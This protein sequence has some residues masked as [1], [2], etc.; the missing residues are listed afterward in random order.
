M[1]ASQAAAAAAGGA[2]A[3]P[4]APPATDW[5]WT[6]GRAAIMYLGVQFVMGP[7][8]PFASKKGPQTQPSAQ[9][10][11]ASGDPTVV[12]ASSAV[13]ARS[14][15]VL[16]GA[17]VVPLAAYGRPTV[18]AWSQDAPLDFYVY[19]SSAPAPTHEDLLT[20]SSEL[21][22]GGGTERAPPVPFDA[23]PQLLQDPFRPDA[24]S[25]AHVVYAPANGV[26][27]GSGSGSLRPIAAAKWS[28]IGLGDFAMTR[29]VDFTLKLDDQVRSNNGSIWADLVVT[30]R[31]VALNKLDRA[32]ARKAVLRTRKLLTRLLPLKRKRE[33][34]NLFGGSS[35]KSGSEAEAGEPDA[36]EDA[37]D[38][39]APPPLVGHWHTNLSVALVQ[40]DNNPQIQLQQLPPPLRQY[41]HV[42]RDGAGEKLQDPTGQFD[43]RF[44]TVFPNDFWLLKEHMTP[45]NETVSEVRL[46]IHLYHQT[47]FK[48]QILA[49]VSDAFDKQAS[50]AGGGGG[51]GAS[52]T[53]SEIDMLKTMLLETNPWF[54]AL[55]VTVSLLHSLF[56]FLAFSSDVR[57]WKNKDNLAGVS[58]GSILTNV[59]VQIIITLYLLDNNEETSWMILAGQAV[60]VLIEVW[61]LTKA[62]TV[63]L[64]AAPPGSLVPFRLKISDKHV[65]SEEEK[66]TQEYDKLA[67][68]YVGLVAVPVLVAYTVYSALYQTHRGWWSFIISTATSF[69][70]AFGF[71]SLVPQLIVNYKLKSTAGMNTKTFV[72]KIL[73]TFVDDLFA[74]C[75]KMPTLHRLAC[76]RDDIVFFIFL[77]QRWIYGIDPTRR[78]EFGQVVDPKDDQDEGGEKDKVKAGKP[79][80]P[81]TPAVGALKASGREEQVRDGLRPRGSATA[82]EAKAEQ[83]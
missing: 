28:D 66:R 53:G 30:P 55:T 47:F 51:M 68:K 83:E 75:I 60:G 69:V 56:E 58:L 16:P 70:Y 23:F 79:T 46:H 27:S 43:L 22:A 1:P 14:S 2:P 54:L 32:S 61:K 5:K 77:Y 21:V 48:F 76:F 12:D 42:P 8:G 57:H 7:N 33:E 39:K 78:N 64:V 49:S 26:A 59:V 24:G 44:P 18:P 34:K 15:P 72:Y 52:A 4:D 35:S 13:P 3:Q 80:T 62:V 31:G 82:G 20:Q 6:L 67:F 45:I 19:I 9:Q 25:D 11:V 74:F 38:A 41:I 71:V 65:L 29:D 81:A 17:E 73:G 63:G 50:G 37:V 36:A 10:G 40:D